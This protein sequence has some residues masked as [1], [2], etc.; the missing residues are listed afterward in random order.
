LRDLAFAL[1][2]QNLMVSFRHASGLL[3]VSTLVV[4][5]CSTS[6]PYRRPASPAEAAWIL[7]GPGKNE[8]ELVVASANGPMANRGVLAPFDVQGYVFVDRAGQ[9]VLIPF[10]QTLSVTYKSRTLGATMGFFYGA[11]PGLLAGA[12]LGSM[13]GC[14][15]SGDRP[16]G[17]SCSSSSGRDGLAIGAIGG[18]V[19]GGIGAAIGAMIGKDV[20]MT[21]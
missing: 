18:L 4:A 20:T 15:P 3:M 14:T 21:F 19:T 6:T 9:A 16:D 1:Q 2:T 13:V 5:G 8:V 7:D 12:L 10:E 17:S 11:L